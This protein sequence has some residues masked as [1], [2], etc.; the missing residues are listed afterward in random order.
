MRYAVKEFRNRSVGQADIG[1]YLA[2]LDDQITLNSNH[3][4]LSDKAQVSFER[5]LVALTKELNTK[6][7][8]GA[9]NMDYLWLLF[10]GGPGDHIVAQTMFKPLFDRIRRLRLASYRDAPLP[11]FRF[12]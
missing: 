4:G 9:I 8:Q 10:S 1:P 3:D 7:S 2:D 11:N 12:R 6:L 5:A